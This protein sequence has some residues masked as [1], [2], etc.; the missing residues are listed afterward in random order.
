MGYN[1]PLAISFLSLLFTVLPNTMH[2]DCIAYSTGGNQIEISGNF[3]LI[4]YETKNQTLN[5]PLM[6]E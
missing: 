3:R 2:V 5:I 4:Q 1:V 6:A